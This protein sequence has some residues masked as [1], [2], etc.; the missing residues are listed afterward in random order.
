MSDTDTRTL[1]YTNVDFCFYTKSN[2][3]PRYYVGLIWSGKIL[4]KNGIAISTSQDIKIRKI[5]C[6]TATLSSKMIKP[7]IISPHDIVRF[8]SSEISMT[9][10]DYLK[11]DFELGGKICPILRAF[12]G[13]NLVILDGDYTISEHTEINLNLLY[14][15][16]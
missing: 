8:S 1:Q 9:L 5:T 6:G 12:V 14:I 16:C 15:N 3:A 13:V 10:R 11:A 4:P 2:L 7:L